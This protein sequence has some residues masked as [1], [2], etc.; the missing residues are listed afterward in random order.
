MIIIN[1]P[2][3]RE[4][5]KKIIIETVGEVE[6]VESGMK[7]SFT[8]KNEDEDFKIIKSNIKADPVCKALYCQVTRE[9]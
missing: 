4:D 9:D 1:A 5:F 3:K 8:T 2:L 7:L 6:I